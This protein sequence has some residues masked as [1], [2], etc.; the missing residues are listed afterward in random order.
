[1]NKGTESKAAILRQLAEE[2]LKNKAATASPGDLKTTDSPSVMPSSSLPFNFS[3]ANLAALLYEIEVNQIELEMQNDELTRAKEEAENASLKYSELYDY[4]PSGYFSL[5]KDGSIT[6]LNYSG[7][8]LLN[9]E[10][11]LLHNSLFAF[12]IS[13]DTRPDFTLFLEKIFAHKTS[14]NCE[15][16][17]ITPGIDPKEVY[18]TGKVDTHEENALIVATDITLRK[19]TELK[20]KKEE[21]S[22]HRIISGTNSGTWEWNVQ[23]GETTF[24]ERWANIIGYT[25]QEISPVS[26]ETWIRFTHPED[27]ICSDH[28]LKKHFIG[29]T[30]GYECEARMRHKNGE[31]I[32]VLDKGKVN[33]WT[34]DGKPLIMSGIHQ[35]ITDRK[36]SEADLLEKETQYYNLANAGAALIWRA[37]TDKLCNYFNNIWLEFTGRTLE[38]EMGNGWAEGVH[39]DD[40]Q[41]CLTIFTTSFDKREYFEMEYRLLHVSGEYRW[42][43]D[44]GKPNYNLSGEF[45][46]YIGHCFDITSRKQSDE[47][48]LDKMNQLEQ[49]QRLTVNRELT[50]IELKKEINEMLLQTGQKAK[51]VIVE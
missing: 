17:L 41:R 36:K 22:L 23:T 46:G 12:F 19:Q 27:L 5:S 31:W 37:G 42:L 10:R 32:W 15:V 21:E 26:I 49:F 24:N 14:E 6:K 47:I 18:L 7:A 16:T 4:A 34:K 50:M 3:E 13:D 43:L 29:E 45:V 9:K 35:D 39:P 51:Y 48:L 44:M 33:T 38:Q 2:L 40:L 1:M 30:A 20:L 25:L 8:G 11:T 28:L